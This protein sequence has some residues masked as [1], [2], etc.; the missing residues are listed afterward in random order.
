MVS[1][2]RVPLFGTL[3]ALSLVFVVSAQGQVTPEARQAHSAERSTPGALQV[4]E[5]A[6]L[7]TLKSLDGSTETDLASFREKKPVVLLFGSY[8]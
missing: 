1:T 6:P 8:T 7:F 3:V 2:R 4:G 5:M